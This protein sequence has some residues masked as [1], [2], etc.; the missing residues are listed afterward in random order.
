MSTLIRQGQETSRIFS[1]RVSTQGIF[2]LQAK[3]AYM[4]FTGC[5]SNLTASTC[6]STVSATS[7]ES[8]SDHI[9]A[10]SHLATARKQPSHL[11]YSLQGRPLQLDPAKTV[12]VG[13]QSA[14]SLL[15]LIVTCM[16]ACVNKWLT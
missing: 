4:N 7:H 5:S 15:E 10:T 1:T 13:Q 16:I 9:V 8:V 3:T 11:S 2:L 12:A 14:V 6:T